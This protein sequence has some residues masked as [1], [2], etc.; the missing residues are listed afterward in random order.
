M[1]VAGHDAEELCFWGT[2]GH[3]RTAHPDISLQGFINRNQL[4]RSIQ[5]SGIDILHCIRSLCPV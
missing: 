3:R 4:I 2:G 1:N 5:C